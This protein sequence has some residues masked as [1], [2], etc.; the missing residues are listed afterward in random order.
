LVADVQSIWLFTAYAPQVKEGTNR[1]FLMVTWQ[2]A[3]PVHR[4][5]QNIGSSHVTEQVFTEFEQST[6]LK[7]VLPGDIVTQEE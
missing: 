3:A 2:S 7:K 1:L 4:T 5:L 6:K